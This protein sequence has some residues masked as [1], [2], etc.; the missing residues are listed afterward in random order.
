MKKARAGK[1]ATKPPR[2]VEAYLKMVENDKPVKACQ[3]Q[4]KL[5]NLVRK[6]FASGEIYVNREQYNAYIKIGEAM[7][8]KL[9]PW[10][11][12]LCCLLLCTY[13]LK[14]DRPRWK[15][16]LIMLAR[17][18]G[19]DGVIAWFSLCLISKNNPIENYNIDICANNEAQ[20]LQPVKD[21]VD[22]L[23]KPYFKDA[24][25]ASFYWTSERIEGLQ[26]GGIIKGHTNN[27][28][29]KDGLRSGCVILNEIHQYQDYSNIDVFLTGL[30]KK[31]C[32]RSIYFTTN[33]HVREGVLD[34]ELSQAEDVLNEVMDDGGFFPFIC[35]IDDKSEAHDESCWYKA[36]PSLQYFPDLLDETKTDYIK[37]KDA[38]ATLP[39]FMAKRM[40]LPSLQSAMEVA[41]Y[42]LIK[43][44]NQPIPYDKIKKQRC[45]VGIDTAQTTDFM[46]VSALFKVDGKK[47]VLNHTWV[48]LQSKDLPRVKFKSQ[49]PRLVEMGLLTLVDGAEIPPSLVIDYIENWKRNYLIQCVVLDSFKLSIFS[50]GLEQ[51]GFSTK[52]K[53]LKIVRPLDVG[54]TQPVISSAFINKQFVWGDNPMLRWATNNTKVKPYNGGTALTSETGAYTFGKIE[55]KSRKNDPFMSLAHA[56]TEETNLKEAKEFNPN[57]FKARVYS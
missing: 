37:W 50:Q 54:R 27:A 10:Q 55:P 53:N 33:G 56:M 16:A 24:N 15:H 1:P 48:C 21:A 36:N 9:F 35:R 44:T 47:I 11:K 22:F 45:V 46:S 2:D 7:F 26:N 31:A 17:G 43:E 34:D 19:K 20:S 49:F 41:P 39:G 5:A 4:K 23:N 57:I 38:P 18:A 42:E 13:Q 8:P 40:N 14:D 3:D 30:G 12:F 52:L 6:A 32:P 51:I 29:G 28:K 25:K